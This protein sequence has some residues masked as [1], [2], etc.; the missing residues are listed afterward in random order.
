MLGNN[1]V[2]RVNTELFNYGCVMRKLLI[3]RYIFI[4]KHIYGVYA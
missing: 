3:Y 1:A 2:S 4:Y